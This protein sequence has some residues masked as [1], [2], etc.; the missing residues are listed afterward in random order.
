MLVNYKAKIKPRGFY[1]LDSYVSP[2]YNVQN[3][4]RHDHVYGIKSFLRFTVLQFSFARF[5]SVDL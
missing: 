1:V 5:F 2:F 3:N 4:I